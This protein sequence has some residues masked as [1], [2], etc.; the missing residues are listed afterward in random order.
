M[1]TSFPLPVGPVEVKRIDGD[2]APATGTVNGI[3]RGDD[4]PLRHAKAQVGAVMA[5]AIGTDPLK[6]YGDAGLVSKVC[7]GEK[8]PD[9]LARIYQNPEARRRFAQAWLQDTPGVRMTVTFEFDCLQE[10]RTA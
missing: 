5:A 3:D 10:R 6:C 8:A 1:A 4:N 7:S 9:Y 2:R